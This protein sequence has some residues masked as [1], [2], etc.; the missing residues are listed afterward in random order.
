MSSPAAAAWL[1]SARIEAASGSSVKV[2][3]GGYTDP[4]GL[5]YLIDRYYDPQTGQFLS[6]DPDVGQTT[7]P[8]GYAAG[9]PVNLTDPE[10]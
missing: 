5:I 8:Y 9:D 1:A 2:F 6:V 3:A 4:T 7:D 10:R